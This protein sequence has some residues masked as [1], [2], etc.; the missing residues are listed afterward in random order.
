MSGTTTT[1]LSQT[2]DYVASNI[3][4]ADMTVIDDAIRWALYEM[5][6]E[7]TLLRESFSVPLVVN[8]TNYT[9]TPAT[10]GGE[11]TELISAYITDAAWRI[12]PRRLDNVIPGATGRPTV[13][14]L[15][16]ARTVQFYPSPTQVETVTVLAAVTINVNRSVA[17]AVPYVV[18]P[19]F[20]ALAESA[21][22]FL[23]RMPDKPWSSLVRGE[24]ARARDKLNYGRI[25]NDLSVGRGY[26]GRTRVF[27][28]FGV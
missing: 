13:M 18:Q 5:L 21:I 1:I 7:T 8:Q 11:V 2:R 22:G 6:K 10:T 20:L 16:D 3:A 4:A 14:S 24:A 17:L 27:N 26:G 12:W 25:K 28:R 23:Q 19:Y 15:G 9:L